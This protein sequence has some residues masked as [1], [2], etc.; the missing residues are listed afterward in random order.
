MELLNSASHW[1]ISMERRIKEHMTN[2]G[3][4]QE[5]WKTYVKSKSYLG[6][7]ELGSMHSSSSKDI[8]YEQNCFQL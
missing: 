6:Y 5:E 8:T 4:S 1:E 3:E 7:S 2:E